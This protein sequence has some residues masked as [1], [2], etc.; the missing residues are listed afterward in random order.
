MNEFMKGAVCLGL[1]TILFLLADYL[2]INSL[3]DLF[4]LVVNYN[5]HT[6]G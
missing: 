5:W 4:W 1:V 2:E 6:N 3:K